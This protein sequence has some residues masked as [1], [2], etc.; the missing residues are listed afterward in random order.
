MYTV[1]I[2]DETADELFKD[3][4]I[5]D[6]LFLRKTIKEMQE[7]ADKLTEFELE[8]LEDNIRWA[9]AMEVTME[10]YIEHERRLEL[11]GK[12]GG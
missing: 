11:I 2:S 9:S 5:Q 8:D 6:Y 4:F 1:E 3:I 10:Y 12:D 7:K